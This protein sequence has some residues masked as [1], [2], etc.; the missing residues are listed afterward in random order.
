MG[1]KITDKSELMEIVNLIDEDNDELVDR[2][3][4][5]VWWAD[6]GGKNKYQL[7]DS[8]AVF[9]KYDSDRSG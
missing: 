6:N 9:Q 1:M 5:A 4:F 3:E 8:K 2:N 7:K